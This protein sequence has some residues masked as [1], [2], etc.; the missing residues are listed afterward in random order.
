MDELGRAL[1]AREGQRWKLVRHRRERHSIRSSGRSGSLQL[2]PFELWAPEGFG[3][4]DVS[5]E[6]PERRPNGAADGGRAVLLLGLIYFFANAVEFGLGGLGHGRG[7][8]IDLGIFILAP[9][10]SLPPLRCKIAKGSFT[11]THSAIV[12]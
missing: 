12:V 1:V 6:E 2:K 8:L 11:H 9:F 10:R 7:P 3:W 4:I 5:A